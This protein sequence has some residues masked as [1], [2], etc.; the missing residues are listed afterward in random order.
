[1]TDL[2]RPV[3]VTDFYLA[4][5]LDELKFISAELIQTEPEYAVTVG[6]EI[7]LKEPEKLVEPVYT[8]LPDNFPGKD[9]LKEAGVIYLE[10]VPR[11]GA[12]LVEINGI[13]AA[14]A[15]KILTWF[16]T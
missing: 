1:M 9:A 3:S 8:P 13:G 5:V 12:D 6:G 2:P 7:E 15:N 10:S 16:K 4:A 11:L 14:T